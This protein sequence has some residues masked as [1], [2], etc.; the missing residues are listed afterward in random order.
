MIKEALISFIIF[1][2]LTSFNNHNCLSIK[3][4][5]S[6]DKEFIDLKVWTADG[7]ILLHSLKP[8]E[9]SNS[10]PISWSYKFTYAEAKTEVGM[11]IT[12]GYC[13]SGEKRYDNGEML[14]EF[15]ITSDSYKTYPKEKPYLFIKASI[16]DKMKE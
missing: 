11:F 8:G 9:V 3:F 5:N 6:T 2:A 12:P 7:D 13:R 10:F 14:M 4:K 16:L 1:A 15:L